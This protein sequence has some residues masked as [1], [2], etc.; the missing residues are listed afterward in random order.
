MSEAPR[1]LI[2]RLSAFGDILHTL[3][4]YRALRRAFPDAEVDWLV[5]DRWAGVLRT[6]EGI[7]EVI[8]VSRRVG[9]WAK[10]M[11]AY[12]RLRKRLSGRGYQAAVD[13]QGLT[14]SGVWPWLARVPMR[15]G[16]GDADG[17]ELSR[18]FYTDRVLPDAERVHVVERN[19][20]LVERVTGKR[21]VVMAGDTWFPPDADAEAWAREYWERNSLGG[22]R[23]AVVNPCA[24][25]ATKRWEPQGYAAVARGLMARG[26][27]CLVSWG[28]GE[29]ATAREVTSGAGGAATLPPMTIHQLAEI[30]RRSSLC[31]SGDTGPLHLAAAVGLPCVAIFGGSDPRRNG[32]YRVPS[33]IVT[34]AVSCAPCWKTECPLGHLDCLRKLQPETVM[35][36]VEALAA[37]CLNQ[38]SA[39]GKTIGR[40]D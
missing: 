25:W 29:E 19:L 37:E 34:F 33:R 18:V 9:G 40:Q 32:P 16:Y 15:V 17:R 5:E 11:G 38:D 30:L 3:P 12:G 27:K 22:F 10:G 28:P 24:R 6:V 4:A 14:K 8:P 31:V 21:E 26:W 1:F 39:A 23:V 36:E 35:R 13:L 20:A 7:G 2:V